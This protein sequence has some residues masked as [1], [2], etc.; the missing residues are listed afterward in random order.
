VFQGT[1]HSIYCKLHAPKLFQYADQGHWDKIPKRIQHLQGK[2]QWGERGQTSNN[3]T[4]EKEIL[5]RHKYAPADT[6]LHR[7]VRPMN[8]PCGLLSAHDALDSVT[9]S[10]NNNNNILD[11]ETDPIAQQ[12]LSEAVHAIVTACPRIVFVQDVFG[13]TPLHL[14]CTYPFVLSQ[15]DDTA[16]AALK[17]AGNHRAELAL[18]LLITS[19][20]VAPDQRPSTTVS[21][22]SA[23]TDGSSLHDDKESQAETVDTSRD[24][25][26]IVDHEKKTALHCVMEHVCCLDRG[27]S[28]DVVI[29]ANTNASFSSSFVVGSPVLRLVQEL[30][31]RDPTALTF[32]NSRGETVM[33]VIDRRSR[34][35]GTSAGAWKQLLKQAEQEC[36]NE[37]G[38]NA[39][40]TR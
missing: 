7:L 31:R 21:V 40:F 6:A 5:F 29:E 30:V 22:A 33:D 13:R 19:D 3:K 35:S 36:Q 26:A 27:P 12:W 39:T 18:L 25:A 28:K 17:S 24:L 15:N 10:N 2:H 1:M 9:V 23:V 14:A 20:T 16:A 32:Q 37:N 4:L 38:P 34:E 8:I 11:I